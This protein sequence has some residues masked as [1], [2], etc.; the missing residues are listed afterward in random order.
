M[1]ATEIT[2]KPEKAS[3]RKK[4]PRKWIY[5][6]CIFLLFCIEMAIWT[7][8]SATGKEKTQR[9]KLKSHPF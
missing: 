1:K 7:V 9:A 8:Q 2:A 3:A 6:S 4:R 5:M